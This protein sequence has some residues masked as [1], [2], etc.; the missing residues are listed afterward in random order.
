VPETRYISLAE[1][2][3]PD[4]AMRVAMDDIKLRELRENMA[5]LGLIQPLC[6][7][8]RDGRYVI[9]DGHRRFTCACDLGWATIRC[10]VYHPAEIADGAVMVAANRHREDPSAAEEALLFAE[11]REKY[12][13][14]EA[15]LCA[16]FRV[17]PDYLGERFRLLRGDETVFAAV[18]ARRISFAVARELNRCENEAHRRYLLDVAINTG[19]SSRVMADHVRQWR[20]AGAPPASA[21][22][23]SAS[24]EP[25]APA[26]E[27]K[28]ECVLCGGYRDPWNLES[29]LIHKAEL[30]MILT[31]LERAAKDAG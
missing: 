12:N 28:Q 25:A 2:D 9:E 31:Q 29:V 1:I 30:Q 27:Y 3:P 6:V 17:S 16:R 15:G 11:H 26:P 14:D 8:A 22:P 4:I 19:Y 7:V 24:V 23:S 20:A 10:E 21:Q 18:L 5:E 13:L